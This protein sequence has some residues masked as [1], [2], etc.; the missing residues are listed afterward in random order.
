MIANR[1]A[2]GNTDGSVKAAGRTQC[3]RQ[4]CLSPDSKA[5]LEPHVSCK[6]FPD[7]PLHVTGT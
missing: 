2:S 4:K 6:A 5:P 3:G 7:L 1:Y